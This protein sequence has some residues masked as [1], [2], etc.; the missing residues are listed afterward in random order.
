MIGAKERILQFIETQGISVRKFCEINK[1]SHSIFTQKGGI[2]SDKLA[3]IFDNY[4]ILNMDWVITGRGK[5]FYDDSLFGL[6]QI[7]LSPDDQAK[8][9]QY[10]KA[11]ED[12]IRE[13]V[14]EELKEKNKRKRKA[15]SRRKGAF[16]NLSR[17]EVNL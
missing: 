13:I 16:S 3:K 6:K 11:S 15:P 9:E 8:W 10:L 12:K 2:N 7:T 17:E 14:R 4:S 1:L 5:M